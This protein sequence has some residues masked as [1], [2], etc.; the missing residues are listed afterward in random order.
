MCKDNDNP[1]FDFNLC[2]FCFSRYINYFAT[3]AS[4]TDHILDLWEARHREES[5]ITD[6]M[7]I[8]RVMGRMDAAAVLE[9][10]IGSWL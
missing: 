4:P 8:L 2:L 5:A 10:D 6:L 7:N 3:K 9:K 1:H